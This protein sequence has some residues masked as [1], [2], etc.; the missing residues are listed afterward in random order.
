[1]VQKI[2]VVEDDLDIQELT[3]EFLTANEYV[4][5]TAN[6][7]EQGY[8]KF[9]EGE[10]DLVMLDVNMPKM[11]GFTVCKMIRQKSNVPIIML[12][13]L[14]EEQDQLKGFENGADDY[15]TKPFSFNLLIKRVEAVLRRGI[16]EAES[17]SLLRFKDLEMDI[18]AYTVKVAGERIEMTSKEFQILQ[19]MLESKGKVWTRESLLDRVWGYDFFGDARVIDTHIKNVRRKLDRPYIQTVKGIGYKVED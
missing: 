1:M 3:K 5:D 11:D 14:E 8:L 15:I 2:L 6:D 7:G 12:T 16:T 4:V 18:E 9:K 19:T 13:A 10:Y 17:G